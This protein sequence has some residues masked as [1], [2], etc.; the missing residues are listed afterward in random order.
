[1]ARRTSLD[2]AHF[3]LALAEARAG[4]AEGGLPIGAALAK[5]TEV[6]ARGRNR[7][8]QNGSVIRHAEMDCL[9]NAG[10]L[11]AGAYA[12]T[13]L[14]STLSPCFMCSGAVIHFGIPRLVV[15]GDV[16]FTDR[17]ALLEDH[18]VEVIVRDDREALALIDRFIAEQPQVW[19]EDIGEDPHEVA[20]RPTR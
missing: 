1:M 11:P 9:E 8:V 4:Q 5:R 15:G 7:R 17:R 10:R 19:Y 20:T 3:A 13:T 6:L 2:D 14:Y 18:G 12:D 16:D